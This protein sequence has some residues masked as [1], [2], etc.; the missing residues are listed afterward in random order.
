MN[1][2]T[3]LNHSFIVTSGRKKRVDLFLWYKFKCIINITQF[4]AIWKKKTGN[5]NN[6]NAL[7]SGSVS[8]YKKQM[9]IKIIIPKTFFKIEMILN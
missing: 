9:F 3:Y 8:N 5:N 2:F 4:N 1:Y 7:V 6:S